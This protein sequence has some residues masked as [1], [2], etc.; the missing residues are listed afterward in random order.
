MKRLSCALAVLLLVPL[1][2]S[3]ENWPGWRGPG[4]SGQSSE[5]ALPSRWSEKENIK[6]KIDLPQSGSASPVVWGSR[7]FLAQP[8]DEKGHKRA[9]WCL[10]RATGKLLWQSVVSYADKEP[11]HST[12]PFCS[13]TPVTDGER[14]ITSFGSA[15]L[16]CY[17]MA[18]KEQWHYEL[19]KLY[20]IWGNASSPILYQ[21]L[22]I[23]W[24]GPGERQF[25]VALD[26]VTGK[27]VW[28]H[29][30]PGGS[31][32]TKG[33]TWIGSWST[34]IVAR[35]ADR[36]ELILS[37]PDKVKAFDPATGKELWSCAGLSKLV[38]TSPTISADGIVVAFSGYGGPA[39]AVRAG[40]NGDV[41]AT[42]RLWLQKTNP[43]RIGSPV[44][45]GEHAYLVSETGIA[46]CFDLKTGK[47]LW[48][49]ENL[50]SKTWSTLIHA[51]GKLFITD[52]KAETLVLD[53]SPTFK[54]RGR[55]S[56]GPKEQTR[57]TL[58]IADGEIYL[59]TFRHLYCIGTVK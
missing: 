43:Q 6:W 14:V 4:G 59:R 30:E 31:D 20:H 3:A 47:D 38:Y 12:N 32:G 17:D 57:A 25:L 24:A 9:L 13:A 54:Q 28:Q 55:N 34:P 48:N 16:Y 53:P 50:H 58:A 18:G 51:D 52:L 44:I 26:K 49:K 46:H 35:V 10:D 1:V 7:I 5:K 40:G 27:K 23:M 29:D 37:V 41:T 8:L 56:L 15:G 33:K 36:D 39:L 22:V 21:N 11:T 42:H 45:L 2:A 19:G